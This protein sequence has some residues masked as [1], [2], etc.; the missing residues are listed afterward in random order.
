MDL[1]FF[2]RGLPNAARH[3]PAGL[4]Y[5]VLTAT[6]QAYQAASLTARTQKR[7]IALPACEQDA[8]VEILLG[9]PRWR[10]AVDAQGGSFN[11]AWASA[12]GGHV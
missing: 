12:R 2:R 10:E 8:L 4:D 1:G 9:G 3:S 5:G 6:L 7:S 11:A